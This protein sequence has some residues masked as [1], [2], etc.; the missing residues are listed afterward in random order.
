MIDPL[1]PHP[2]KNQNSHCPFLFER[3]LNTSWQEVEV[4]DSQMLQNKKQI[5]KEEA[6]EGH[7]LAE[8]EELNHTLSYY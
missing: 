1:F 5:Q 6:E 7:F 8:V 3:E 4:V 2:L